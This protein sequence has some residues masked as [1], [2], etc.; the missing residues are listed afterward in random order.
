[1]FTAVTISKLLP[2]FQKPWWG[3]A[4]LQGPCRDLKPFVLHPTDRRVTA[5]EEFFYTWILQ[6]HSVCQWASRHS[7]L[8]SSVVCRSKLYGPLPVTGSHSMN[9]S[10]RVPFMQQPS[11]S[12]PQVSYYLVNRLTF[13]NHASYIYRTGVPLPSRCCILYIFSTTISTGYFKHAAHSPFYSS[14]CRLF[15]NATFFGSCIINILHTGV[16]KFKC[17]I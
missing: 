5:C 10:S 12:R 13:K 2:V 15:H 6:R 14:K 3:G 1:M 16:L 4:E 17:K 9:T 7:S 8:L 11:K